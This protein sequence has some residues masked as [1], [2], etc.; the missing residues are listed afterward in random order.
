MKS[1]TKAAVPF[2]DVDFLRQYPGDRVA[3]HEVFMSF[4]N[5]QDA[6]DFQ[7]WWWESGAVEFQKWRESK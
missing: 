2:K 3:D 5:D 1:K 6:I 7:E 4:V